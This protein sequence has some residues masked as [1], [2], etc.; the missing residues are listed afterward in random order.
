MISVSD[1]TIHTVDFLIKTDD[2]IFIL[3]FYRFLK[4]RGG[5]Y[6]LMEK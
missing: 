3:C 2:L 1:Y 4:G 5:K 6:F